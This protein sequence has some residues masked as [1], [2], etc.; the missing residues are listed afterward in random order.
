MDAD[1]ITIW[2]N[3]LADGDEQA[4]DRIW[5]RYWTQMI[6]HARAKLARLPLRASDEEDVALS[7]MNSFFQGVA[8]NRFPDVDNRDDLRA[9][10]LFIT[11]RKVTQHRRK[12]FR[13]KRGGGRVVS[14]SAFAEHGSPSDAQLVESVVGREPTPELAAEFCEQFQNLLVALGDESLREIAVWKLDGYTNDEIAH[15][16]QRTTRSV[17]RK[18]RLIREIWE[19]SNSSN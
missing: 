14:A 2:F 12:E 4:A 3:R 16:I 9:L 6:G 1:S 7:A 19:S 17:E 10:L 15:R 11:A 5:Q 13:L 18:L 8:A